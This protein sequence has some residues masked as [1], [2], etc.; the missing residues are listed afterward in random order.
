MSNS[1]IFAGLLFLT[2][3]VGLNLTLAS[4]AEDGVYKPSPEESATV[5]VAQLFK[6]EDA[7]YKPSP[8]GPTAIEE[9]YAQLEKKHPPVKN[10]NNALLFD[11]T[12]DFVEIPEIEAL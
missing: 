10:G 11:G 2:T 4:K 3:L 5:P 1:K 6:P 12:G 9:L 8:E 7:V